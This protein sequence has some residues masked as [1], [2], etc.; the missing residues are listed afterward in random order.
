MTN[1]TKTTQINKTQQTKP[2][3]IKIKLN[4]TQHNKQTRKY[5]IKQANKQA[6]K[7]IITE[8]MNQSI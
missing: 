4:K 7:Q 2:D 8:S 3:Q 5:S 6:N 1:I